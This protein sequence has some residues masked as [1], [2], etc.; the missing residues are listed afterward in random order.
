[1][2][3]A[4]RYSKVAVV[5]LKSLR[6]FDRT[7]ILDQIEQYLSVNPIL[8]S[9]SKVKQLRQ[10]APNQYRLRVGEF[11]IFYDVDLTNETV[12]VIQVL[13]KK[14]AMDYLEGSP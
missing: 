10:P 14:D 6:P 9:K 11:R 4:I 12:D 8:A 1:M 2:P 7:A 13:S 3:F 5:Q